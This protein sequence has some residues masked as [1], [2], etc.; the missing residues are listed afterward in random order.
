M[1]FRLPPSTASSSLTT[2]PEQPVAGHTAGPWLDDEGF[3]L[4]EPNRLLTRTEDATLMG[5]APEMLA[6]LK[7]ADHALAQFTAFE[8]DCR[9]IMG[10]TNFAIVQHNREQVRAAISRATGASA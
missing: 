6:A 8:L 4:I 1:S 2:T 5:R 3:W 9:E 7:I 10:N